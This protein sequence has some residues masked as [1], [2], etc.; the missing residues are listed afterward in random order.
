MIWE[1]IFD[2]WTMRKR[3]EKK[4]KIIFWTWDK[5]D[6]LPNGSF[7]AHFDESDT[8]ID[9]F[10]MKRLFSHFR[11]ASFQ[12]CHRLFYRKIFMRKYFIEDEKIFINHFYRFRN[13]W[14]SSKRESNHF[15][16]RLGQRLFFEKI[17]KLFS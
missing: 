16:E 8:L 15:D 4:L 10:E 2:F 14:K 1:M 9:E 17:D 7:L 13:Q 5:I 11:Y 12:L 6:E 3:D